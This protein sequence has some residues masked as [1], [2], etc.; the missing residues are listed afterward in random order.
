MFDF[1]KPNIEIAEI[2]D[3]KKYGRFVVEPLE[4]GYGTTT[5]NVLQVS[6]TQ[7]QSYYK[8]SGSIN[9]Q[10]CNR[11]SFRAVLACILSPHLCL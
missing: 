9:K 11:L 10:Y 2:S 8:G 7:H 6:Y 1:N 3:D 5:G 4:R